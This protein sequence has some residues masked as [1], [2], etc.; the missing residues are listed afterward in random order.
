[1]DKLN[2]SRTLAWSNK[3]RS[4]FQTNPTLR[5]VLMIRKILISK[6][7]ICGIILVADGVQVI[8]FTFL[9]LSVCHIII[10]IQFL[11]KIEKAAFIF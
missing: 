5:L 6:D 7:N 8:I 3:L 10:I 2:T 11:L 9:L 1:M 4:P